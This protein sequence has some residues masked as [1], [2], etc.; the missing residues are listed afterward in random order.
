M[1]ALE[2]SKPKINIKHFT[3]LTFGG[4]TAVA[5]LTLCF[6]NT[7]YAFIFDDIGSIVEDLIIEQLLKPIVESVLQLFCDFVCNLTVDSIL[8]ASFEEIFGSSSGATSL[9]D[10]V[11]TVHDTVVVPLG[12][13]ILALV[14]LVQVVKISQRI[15]AT[16]TMPAVKEVVF[17]AAFFVIFTWLINQSDEIC[18]AVYDTVAQITQAIGT[19]SKA[20]LSIS[21]GDS[22]NLTVGTMFSLLLVAL[23]AFIVVFV[24]WV[25]SFVMAY[26]RAIQLYLY[27]V[28]SPI[29][30]ALMGFEETR[31][32]GVNFCKNFIA[33]CLAGAV[34]AFALVAYPLLINAIIADT[35]PVLTGVLEAATNTAGI[36]VLVKVLAVSIVLIFAMVK[37]GAIARD[38]LGG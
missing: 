13:S 32:F 8:T 23:V 38:V 11:Q 19:A 26:F 7:A 12:H 37:S 20:D 1:N 30:F 22:S 17:L 4:L 31:S 5:L 21:L 28:F 27:T 25:L 14:M 36:L 34:M 29:P 16:S 24:A 18:I 35:K 9:Y 33:V 10:L 3:Y 15:D 2:Q 6:P